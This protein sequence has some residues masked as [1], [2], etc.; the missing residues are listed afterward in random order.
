MGRGEG[1]ADE[2]FHDACG[3]RERV[4]QVAAQEFP[5]VDVGG[6]IQGGQDGVAGAGV[7]RQ[8]LVE[9]AFEPLPVPFTSR[10][11]H[12]GQ[13]GQ[14]MF[15]GE[16]PQHVYTVR[17]HSHELWGADAEPFDLTIELFD[18]YLEPSS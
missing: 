4:A 11:G 13:R 1:S 10:P 18:S 6:R 5:E 12:L 9:D 7:S 3:L 14:S 17:F 16:N 8:L 2:S 15:Q